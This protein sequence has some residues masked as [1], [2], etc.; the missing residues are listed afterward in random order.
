M[1]ITLPHRIKPIIGKTFNQLTILRLDHMNE[2]GII[3]YE[4]QCSCGKT[5]IIAGSSVRS[6]NTKSCGCLLAKSMKRVF[7]KGAGELGMTYFTH[8]KNHAKKRNLDWKISCQD[9][10]EQ[11]L[12]QNKKC[13]ISGVSIQLRKSRIDE[14]TASLDRIDSSRGY[15][16]DNI[17]WVHKDINM[18]KQD[19]SDQEFIQW[20]HT[21]SAFNKSHQRPT[22]LDSRTPEPSTLYPCQQ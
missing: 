22:S 14:Q 7:F 17:Q 18:M 6:G 3:F 20:C 19:W 2:K 8:A 1:N 12:R 5:K 11:F 10:W 15:T 16:K 9:A 21:V 4:C 13:A